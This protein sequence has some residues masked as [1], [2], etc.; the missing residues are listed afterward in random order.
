MGCGSVKTL[1]NEQKQIK[2]EEMKNE[3]QTIELPNN[4]SQNQ[5][6]K[7]ENI[8][9]NIK[10]EIVEIENKESS[11]STKKILRQP[12]EPLSNEE[13]TKNSNNKESYVTTEKSCIR[14]EGDSIISAIQSDFPEVTPIIE[15]KDDIEKK[16]YEFEVAANRYE[17]IYPLWLNKG[18]EVEFLVEGKWKINHETECDSK[19]LENEELILFPE[20]V[21]EYFNDKEII[22]FNDGALIGRIIKGKAFLIY[23]GLKYIP[24]ESGPLLLKMNLNNLWSREKPEGKLKVK[25]GGANKI[26][27]L[28][29]F[30]KRSGWWKQLKNVE[31]INE[32]ELQY[33]EIND[34]EK[35]LIILLNKLRHDSNIFA[36]QFLN[37]FQRITNTSKQIYSTFINNKLQLPPL[38][39]NLTMVKLLQTFFEKIFFKETTSEEDWN[40]VLS[41]ENSLQEFLR[42]SFYNKKK[43]H[44]CIVRYNEGNM[45]HLCTRILFRKDIRENILTYEFEEMSMI[46]LFNNWNKVHDEDYDRYKKKNIHYCVFALSNQVGN[47]KINYDVDLSFEKFVE[48]EKMK[49]MLDVTNKSIL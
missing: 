9:K 30:E 29:E 20:K 48:K 32:N 36:H 13:K 35:A 38:K 31:V 12:H 49:K 39:M 44:A 5:I 17:I 42:N 11:L 23:D 8:N 37:N 43:I 16:Y 21:N 7:S 26:E 19:G 6:E 1:E 3:S 27:D 46:I 22:K 40:Y 4:K 28:E 10:V 41:S 15:K 45:M 34:T 33:Y 24:D 18:D 2:I 14:I 47:D 25:I